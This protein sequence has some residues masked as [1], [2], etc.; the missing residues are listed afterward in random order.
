MPYQQRVGQR[1][2]GTLTVLMCLA[3]RIQKH[4]FIYWPPIHHAARPP[5]RLQIEIESLSRGRDV[6]SPF[7]PVRGMQHVR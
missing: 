5:S 4:P 3:L 6:A 7:E 1:P 2:A